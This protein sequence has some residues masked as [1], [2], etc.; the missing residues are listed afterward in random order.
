MIIQTPKENER[1]Q[2]QPRINEILDTWFGPPDSTEFGHARRLWF[3]KDPTFDATLSYRFGDLLEEALA[4]NLAHWSDSAPGILALIVLLDQFPRNCFRDTPRA[5]AGDAQALALA[6]ALVTNGGDQTLPTLHHRVFAYLPF[7][8][9]ETIE[10]QRESVRLF[11][12]LHEE[13]GGASIHHNL[14]YAIRHA[15]VIERFGRFPHRNSI[16]GRETSPE[17]AEWLRKYGGF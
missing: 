9:D 10:S 13:N 8:H 11:T 4:G 6:R 12:A 7:E 5:F 15:E 14:T 17:E 1:P 16:L 3:K 2:P